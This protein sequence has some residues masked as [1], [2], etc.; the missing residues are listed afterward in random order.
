MAAVEV[1]AKA[2]WITKADIDTVDFNRIYRFFVI[3]SPVDGLSSRQKSFSDYGW[4]TPWRKPFSLRRQLNGLS[5]NNEL[6]FSAHKYD[7]MDGEL[8]KADLVEFPPINIMKERVCIYNGQ[9]TQ[10]LSVFFHIRN[11]LAHGRFNIVEGTF[12]MEDVTAKRK[13]M[14]AGSK[15][16][17]ARMVIRTATLI[18]WIDLI[19]GGARE[20]E[21]NKI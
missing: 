5:N 20:L 13:W 10:Y 15:T 17:S 16:C 19:E 11:A 9:R 12:I 3:F 21:T 6:I 18:N 7:N 14:A 1:D 2:H 4:D 8:I